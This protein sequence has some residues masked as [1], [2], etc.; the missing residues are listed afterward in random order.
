MWGGLFVVVY[1]I[2]LLAGAVRS[3]HLAGFLLFAVLPIAI[4]LLHRKIRIVR[5]DGADA[6]YRRR[7]AT[8]GR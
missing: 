2:G 1:L 6:L 4:G 7:L 5:A 3:I 8:N